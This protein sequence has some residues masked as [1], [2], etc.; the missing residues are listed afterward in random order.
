M[1][2]EGD[3]EQPIPSGNRT[4]INELLSR[5]H[6]AQRVTT[7]RIQGS[8]SFEKLDHRTPDGFTVNEIL[9]MWGWHFWTHHRDFVRARG[10][11]INDDPH[12]HVPHYIRQAHEEFGRC[13]GELACLSD[14]YLDVQPPEG[15]RTVRETVEHLLETLEL[16]FPDQIEKAVPKDDANFGKYSS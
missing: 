8:A 3:R 14:E 6:N 11:L 1:C 13:I 9:R 4:E 5:L 12:F 2:H 16:Y 15:G 10:P 7:E